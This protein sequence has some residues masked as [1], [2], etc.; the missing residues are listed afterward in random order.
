MAAGFAGYLAAAARLDRIA[1]ISCSAAGE[2]RGWR[3]MLGSIGQRGPDIEAVPLAV[4]GSG[5]VGAR[6]RR[7]PRPPLRRVPADRAVGRQP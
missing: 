1:A 3:R 6:P 7:G 2:Y 5:P 4:S